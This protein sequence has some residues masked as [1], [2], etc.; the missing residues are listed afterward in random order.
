MTSIHGRVLGEFRRRMRY[1]KFYSR[2]FC[3]FFVHLPDILMI[4]RLALALHIDGAITCVTFTTRLF[5]PVTFGDHLKVLLVKLV[6]MVITIFHFHSTVF[7][8]LS[9]ENYDEDPMDL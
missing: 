6:K 1:I 9:L 4:V 7:L 8:I 2:I 5:L 3:C